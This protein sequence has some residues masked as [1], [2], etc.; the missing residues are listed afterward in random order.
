[1]FFCVDDITFVGTQFNHSKFRNFISLWKIVKNSAKCLKRF[2]LH[3]FNKK[4][5]KKTSGEMFCVLRVWRHL[6]QIQ[7][8]VTSKLYENWPK[9]HKHLYKALSL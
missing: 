6:H 1:M 2:F 8:F 9:W 4:Y 5:V 3:K 7:S